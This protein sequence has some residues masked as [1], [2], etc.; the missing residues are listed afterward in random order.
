MNPYHIHILESAS[1][2]AGLTKELNEIDFFPTFIRGF[3]A[4]CPGMKFQIENM[5]RICIY[6]FTVGKV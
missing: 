1:K 6:Y 5:R 2:S 4:L 3:I